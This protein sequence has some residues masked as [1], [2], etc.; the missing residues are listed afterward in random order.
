MVMARITLVSQQSVRDRAAENS[1][2]MRRQDGLDSKANDCD[3]TL[4]PCGR[5]DS[6][7]EVRHHEQAGRRSE[8]ER[9]NGIPETANQ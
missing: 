8:Q 2:S 1:H 4:W 3:P 5:P 9:A 6:E 7:A